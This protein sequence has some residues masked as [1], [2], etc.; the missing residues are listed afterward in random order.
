MLETLRRHSGA[1]PR[2]ASTVKGMA[3]R[4][5]AGVGDGR[6]RAALQFRWKQWRQKEKQRKDTDTQ[7]RERLPF[8]VVADERAP[9]M[10]AE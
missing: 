5:R 6:Q 3:R 1:G 10:R 7:W 4:A 9:E 8:P 2:L